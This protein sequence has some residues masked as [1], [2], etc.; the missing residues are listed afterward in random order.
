MQPLKLRAYRRR[1]SAS[2]GT[3]LLSQQRDLEE[4]DSGHRQLITR[5]GLLQ[6]SGRFPAEAGRVGQGPN[7]DVR[8][9]ENHR[10]GFLRGVIARF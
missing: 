3:R 4:G 7:K 1:F 2:R 10:L 8:I 5:S 9:E 6:Q